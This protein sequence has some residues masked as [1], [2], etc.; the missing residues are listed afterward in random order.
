[1]TAQVAKVEFSV[2]QVLAQ[3]YDPKQELLY[4]KF[5]IETISP[6]KLITAMLEK[7]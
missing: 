3:V 6:I 4:R 2:P 7:G 1:M 5:G